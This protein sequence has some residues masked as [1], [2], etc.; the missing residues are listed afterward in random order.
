[1]K[2][3]RFHVLSI[4]MPSA[5][6]LGKLRKGKKVRIMSGTGM[7]IIV[8]PSRINPVTRCFTK[9]KG[10]TI[11]LTQEEIAMNRGAEM[12]GM[13]LFDDIRRGFEDLGEKIKPVA[14][15][16]GRVLLP[17]AKDVAKQGLDK[18]A[19]V[20]PQIGETGLSALAMYSG[21]PALVPYAKMAGRAG[22]QALGNLARDEGK[23]ALDSYNPYAQGQSEQSKEQEMIADLP[24]P[25]RRNAPPSRSSVTNPMSKSLA[26]Y[27]EADL[28]MEIAR[29]RGGYSTPLDSSGGKRV[30]SPYVSAVG[31]G[32][33]AGLYAQV[34]GRGLVSVGGT[35][36]RAGSV[37]PALQS[38]PYA[39]NFIQAS[40]LPPAYAQ[41]IKSG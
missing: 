20:A 34:R 30:L 6:V 31:Q 11:E 22:G 32:L 24:M 5:R 10:H 16:A 26:D 35:L 12:E 3:S 39:S 2:D 13:G 27:S 25:P 33:G 21:N 37:P 38:Q 14:D 15:Q 17:I 8:H 19:E 40:R 28:G 29:R 1:M 18:F 7:Q 4:A 41:M 23:K 36:L 9:G